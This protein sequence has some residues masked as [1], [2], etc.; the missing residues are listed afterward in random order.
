MPSGLWTSR[1]GQGVP[2]VSSGLGQD[3]RVRTGNGLTLR[4]ASDL[5]SA[6]QTHE[7]PMATFVKQDV[8]E[9]RRRAREEKL[10]R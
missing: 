8:D 6:Y 9:E 10:A 4:D 1:G 3:A 2:V 5:V 7:D